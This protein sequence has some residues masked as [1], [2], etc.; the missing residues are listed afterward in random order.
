MATALTASDNSIVAP[1]APFFIPSGTVFWV[2]GIELH[3]VK[4]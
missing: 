1:L 3:K 2:P 4:K